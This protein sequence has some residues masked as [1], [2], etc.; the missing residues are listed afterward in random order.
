[1]KNKNVFEKMNEAGICYS[2][3]VAMVWFKSK[4]SGISGK[5]FY[6]IAAKKDKTKLKNIGL[7]FGDS[8]GYDTIERTLNDNEISLFKSMQDDF[9][10]VTQNNDGRVYELKHNSFKKYYNTV[11]KTVSA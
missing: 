1:M 4:G 7:N 3:G 11:C 8:K 10:K 5:D 2:V 6:I 9:I